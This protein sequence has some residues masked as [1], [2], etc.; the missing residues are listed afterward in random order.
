M[1]IQQSGLGIELRMQEG[2]GQLLAMQT[3]TAC[4]GRHGMAWRGVAWRVA[5]LTMNKIKINYSQYLLLIGEVQR[6]NKCV[7]KEKQ[8]FVSAT[9]IGP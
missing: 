6:I 5:G 9:S 1:R 7:K 3:P 4:L 8:T 2:S